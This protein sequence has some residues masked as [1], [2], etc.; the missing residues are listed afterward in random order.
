MNSK[1]K[2]QDELDMKSD[3]LCLGAPGAGSNCLLIL[4][5]ARIA[6]RNLPPHPYQAVYL[7]QR[8]G[9][10]LHKSIPSGLE[11]ESLQWRR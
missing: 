8:L 6:E 1:S 5:S 10:L 11:S 9:P 3:I 4:G 7:R 2:T